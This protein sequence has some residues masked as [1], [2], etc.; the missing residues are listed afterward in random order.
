MKCDEFQSILLDYI[1]CQTDMITTESI[2]KHL[3]T[4]QKCNEQFINWQETI[5][6][7]QSA[8]QIVY[9]MPDFSVK[10]N[11]M[12]YIEIFEKQKKTYNKNIKIWN[13]LASIA[14]AF[15]I[16]FIGYAG[17]SDYSLN[18]TNQID[19]SMLVAEQSLYE[20]QTKRE[21]VVRIA[22]NENDVVLKENVLSVTST[23][24]YSLG[25]VFAGIGIVSFVFRR[26][27][28]K[29]LNDIQN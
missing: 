8:K 27:I 11:V 15:A 13:R 1:D 17:Y 5:N 23:L 18:T 12:N 10:S 25:G 19:N 29:Q 6:E 16:F 14:A 4:C 26:R 3:Q 24:P 22:S 28:E 20:L 21:D 9:D 2:L 7:I